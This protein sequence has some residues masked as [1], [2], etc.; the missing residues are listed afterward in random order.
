MALKTFYDVLLAPLT[1]AKAQPYINVFAWWRHATMSAASARAQASSGLQVSTTQLLSPKLHGTCDG[2]AQEQ[3]EC[4]LEPLQAVAH[5]WLSVAF[6]AGTEQL[7]SSL[8]AK[9]AMWESREDQRDPTQTFKGHFRTAKLEE[10]LH[11]LD[12]MSQD[13]LPE[14]LHS[15]GCNKK[16]SDN[17][18]VLQMAIDN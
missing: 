14:V 8:A 2:W 5:P 12:L 11:L 10:V 6:K 4:I 13:D 9:H 7:Q 18:L 17:A 1:L 3:A 16:K 15:L